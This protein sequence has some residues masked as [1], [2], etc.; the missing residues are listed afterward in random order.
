MRDPPNVGAID[1]HDE[2]LRV[3]WQVT[4]GSAADTLAGERDAPAVGGPSGGHVEPDSV[5]GCCLPVPSALT[6][7]MSA[8]LRSNSA[9]SIVNAILPLGWDPPCASTGAAEPATQPAPK[10]RRCH[11]TPDLHEN[12]PRFVPRSSLAVGEPLTQ[13]RD[14]SRRTCRHRVGDTLR[15]S[16]HLGL[17]PAEIACGP[18]RHFGAGNFVP[19][20]LAR[21]L[22]ADADART[23]TVQ[24]YRISIRTLVLMSTRPNQDPE[25]VRSVDASAPARGHDSSRPACPFVNQPRATQSKVLGPCSSPGIAQDARGLGRIALPMQ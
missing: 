8:V 12:L 19:W 5:R 22:L 20:L 18:T 3:V 2:Q 10:Y 25:G 16:G 15:R 14:L 6:T 13:W 23:S 1:V 11:Q 7:A 4:R 24:V 9:L 21:R 17:Q